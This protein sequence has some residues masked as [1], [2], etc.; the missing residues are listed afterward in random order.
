MSTTE[1]V[2]AQYLDRIMRRIDAEMRSRGPALDKDCVGALGSIALTHL[3]RVEPTQIKTIVSIMGRDGG[4]ITRVFQDL[5]RKG[6]IVKARNQEDG[7]SVMITLSEKGR[8]HVKKLDALL[9][10]IMADVLAPL[11]SS[12]RADLERLLSKIG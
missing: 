10:Y 1:L 8:R 6:L 5:E 3:S 2:T 11:N 7:R 12:E 9:L 4:Q